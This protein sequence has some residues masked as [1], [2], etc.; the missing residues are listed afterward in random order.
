MVYLHLVDFCYGKC[1]VCIYIYIFTPHTDPMGYSTSY[2]LLVVI[3]LMRCDLFLCCWLKASAC[4]RRAQ[5]SAVDKKRAS[6]KRVEKFLVMLGWSCGKN[7]HRLRNHYFRFATCIAIGL[8]FTTSGGHNQ[9]P[10]K[11]HEA[12]GGLMLLKWRQK[13]TMCSTWLI[14]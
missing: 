14:T 10:S 5:N 9:K 12:R 11:K 4:W 3:H 13:N 2:F 7:H 6:E 1:R 8:V